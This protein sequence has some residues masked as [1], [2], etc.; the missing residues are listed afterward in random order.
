MKEQSTETSIHLSRWH[1]GDRESLNILLEKHL[2][3]IREQ[4]HYKLGDKLRKRMETGDVVQEAV[5]QFLKFAPKIQTRSET[6]LRSL[7]LKIAEHVLY[8]K[9]DWFSAKRRNIAMEQPLP[10]DTVL[11]L[12]FKADTKGTPSRLAM[13]N[14]REAWI[15]LGVELLNFEDR[16]V[17]VLR[18][19]DYLSFPEIAKQLGITSDA[20]RMRYKRAVERLAETVGDLRRGEWKQVVA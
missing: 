4:V 5:L 11:F 15:R 13:E 2:P 17:V 12:D 10:S 9:S 6:C 16:R 8:D 1:E 20:A 3:W 18:D 14:E 19:W 7:L